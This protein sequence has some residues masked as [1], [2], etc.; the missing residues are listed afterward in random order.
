MS[1]QELQAEK[2]KAED[3]AVEAHQ[4][5]VDLH[6]Q[7]VEARKQ[8]TEAFRRARGV[9]VPATTLAERLDISKP[10]VTRIIAGDR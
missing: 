5:I 9:G 6:N 8:R 7:I 10:L 2:Q 1:E 4:V 3:E